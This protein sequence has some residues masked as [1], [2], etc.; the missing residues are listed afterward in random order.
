[1]PTSSGRAQVP[2][3]P[4]VAGRELRTQ[5]PAGVRPLPGVR[6]GVATPLFDLLQHVEQRQFGG[7]RRRRGAQGLGQRGE[8]D[9]VLTVG[10]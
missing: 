8:P 4:G 7:A 10:R 5:S 6:A 9:H 3:E 1:L 2:L